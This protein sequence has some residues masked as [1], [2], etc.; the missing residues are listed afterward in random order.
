MEPIQPKAVEASRPGWLRL[1]ELALGTKEV[2]GPGSSPTVEAYYRDS[3]HPEISDDSVPWCAAFVGACLKRAG[4][5]GT[6][7]LMARSYLGWGIK[8]DQ[9]RRG[10]I[11]VMSRGADPALGHVGFWVGTQ[12][13]NVLLLGGNQGDSV[14][15]EAFPKAR[16]LGYRWPATE[17]PA[18][19]ASANFEQAL[20]HVLEMEGGWTDDP[21]DPG[22]AT[23]KGLTVEDIIAEF[24]LGHSEG[25]KAAAT[26]RLRSIEPD[27]VKVIYRDR[28]WVP[29][30]AAELP[31]GLALMHF[32]ASVNHGVGT[33][34]RIL[35]QAVGAEIDGEIGPLTLAAATAREEAKA[36]RSYAE[37]RRSRYRA[38]ATFWRFGRGWLNRVEATETAALSAVR[39]KASTS[40][41]QTANAN[42]KDEPMAT[43]TT[44][45]ETSVAV[46][47]WWG[48]SM[49]I[50]GAVVTTVATVL[51]SVLQ[52]L[53]YDISGDLIRS[54][55]DQIGK[56]VQAIAGVI[57]VA[58]TILG[59][60]RARAPL[61]RR[62]VVIRL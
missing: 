32:D 2:A 40:M 1:A 21:F 57:G 33:A 20:A 31:A 45:Q 35:Q 4:I 25:D 10:A 9:P 39:A 56:S 36:I 15:I 11:T 50:W 26:T 18:S 6:G 54:L 8:L 46:T 22:G 16:V 47:K 28:Y 49:T 60:L 43:Q 23:N 29:S 3:G 27:L 62:D 24:G 38:L 53:G 12:D 30:Q 14:S 42:Q 61:D 34:A 7:S 52:A 48:Q 51:P 41:T 44:E 13:G 58:M 59:R 55:G 17:G 37:L 19:G 5:E